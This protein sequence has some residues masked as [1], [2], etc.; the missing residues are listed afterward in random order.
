MDFIVFSFAWH[1][2]GQTSLLAEARP[3]KHLTW[4]KE[5]LPY[6]L[7]DNHQDGRV[8]GCAFSSS[9]RTP[10]LQLTAEQPSTEECWIP[11]K[12]DTP[13]SRAKKKSQQDSRRGNWHLES[14]RIPA[15]DAQRGQTKPCAHQEMPQRLNQTCLWMFECLLRRYK[16]VVV[17]RRGRGSGCSRHKHKFVHPGT[18]EKGAVTPQGTDPDLPWVSRSLCRGVGWR[19]PAAGSAAGAWQCLHGTFW[20]RSPLSSLPPPYFGLKSNNREG[21]QLH[22][23]ENWIKDW[24][25]SAPPMRTRPSFPHSQSPPSGSFHKPLVLLH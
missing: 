10:K 12:K 1:L 23:S 24:L 20:R 6:Y 9:V 21:T 11:P 19:W 2:T 4:R 25:S 5:F 14:N 8:E 13:C 22:P 17:C 16:S 3:M 15:R 18:Q 7:V